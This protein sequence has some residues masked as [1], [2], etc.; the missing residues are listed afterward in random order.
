MAGTRA[1]ANVG[2]LTVLLASWR[3]HLEASRLSRRAI[4]AYTDDGALLGAF[5]TVRG[6]P[7]AGLSIREHV[8]ALCAGT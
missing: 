4:R 3:L 6:M 5:L 2:Q 8:D 1:P 7:A